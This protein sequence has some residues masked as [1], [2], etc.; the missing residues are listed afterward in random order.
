MRPLFATLSIVTGIIGLI[1]I[2]RGCN[3]PAKYQ[4]V[5][6]EEKARAVQ[7]TQVY[8][9]A[10]HTVT[11]GVG[12]VGLGV[13]ISLVGVLLRNDRPVANVSSDVSELV[14]VKDRLYEKPA[15][16]GKYERVQQE[17]NA[18]SSEESDT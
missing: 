15:D 1:F 4:E 3:Y 17:E 14:S 11:V 18:A 7:V 9:E 5:L 12:I 2:V 16:T 6:S 13:L 8:T 10:M